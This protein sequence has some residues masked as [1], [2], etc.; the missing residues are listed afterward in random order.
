[1]ID[2][3]TDAQNESK[4]HA[5]VGRAIAAGSA[6]RETS[7]RAGRAIGSGCTTVFIGVLAFGLIMS[8]TPWWFKLLGLAAGA[9][10]YAVIGA[11]RR[12]ASAFKSKR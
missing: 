3:P 6:V 10:I 12:R 8:S 1:M 4:A 11:L 5:A 9:G 2:K 7:Q